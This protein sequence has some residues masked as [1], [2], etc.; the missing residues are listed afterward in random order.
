MISYG[1]DDLIIKNYQETEYI[2]NN[3][4]SSSLKIAPAVCASRDLSGRLGKIFSRLK[5]MHLFEAV[6]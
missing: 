5:K 6:L 3:I 4:P 1:G 2:L